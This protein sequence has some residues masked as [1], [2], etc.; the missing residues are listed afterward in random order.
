[1]SITSLMHVAG[2]RLVWLLVFCVALPAC[3]LLDAK[4]EQEALHAAC[5]IEGS[6]ETQSS[7]HV[8]IVL[9]LERNE[10]VAAS[11][12]P[13]RIV[14]HYVAQGTSHFRFVAG[15]GAYHLAAF[16]DANADLIYQPG[17]AFVGVE[18]DHA[19]DCVAGKQ[20]Q[21]FTL[22][23]P[24]T[25]LKEFDQ[26]LDIT[27]LQGQA[28]EQHLAMTLGQRTVLG[29]VV[30]LDDP[31]F[32]E[33]NASD[34]MW[35]PY[36]FLVDS[37]AGIYFLDEHDPRKT[38]VLFVHGING[39]PANFAW[40]LER[41]DRNRFEP[42][43]YTYPSGVYLGAA[44]DHLTQT[45][46]KL[47]LRL[48][49]ERFIVVAHSMGGLVSRGFLLRQAHSGAEVP[50]Y[51]TMS[52]PWDGHEAAAMAEHAPVVVD[53]W[54]DMKPG[55]EYLRGLFT[56]PLP[57]GV[58]HHLLF[59]FAR[60]HASFGASSDHAVTVASQLR[61]EAQHEARRIYGFNDTHTGVLRNDHVAALL[62]ELLA[63]A[64]DES[65]QP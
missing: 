17:E 30:K 3:M 33:E 34:S 58:T 32:D 15:P 49:V 47:Q 5:A 22:T 11:V 42:W 24:A 56:A 21:A 18:D 48:G 7:S 53:V 27:A 45:M 20:L 60:K 57:E 19:I 55:S 8:R 25:P 39:S 59:T 23:I 40:L 38:P 44:A 61:S 4:R 2:M 28:A 43:L 36:E 63:G 13:W 46:A 54:R 37:R 26:T 16:E 64:V 1:M 31:R 10:H 65:R 12:E 29:D 51:I 35:R 41:L 52:T 50:L 6:V 9:L 14:D 62:N